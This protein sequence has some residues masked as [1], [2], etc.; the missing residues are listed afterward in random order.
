MTTP[1]G[2]PESD[3][4]TREPASAEGRFP[5]RGRR[6]RLRSPYGFNGSAATDSDMESRDPAIGDEPPVAE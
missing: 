4:A 6:R 5:G 1:A 2:A 3:L